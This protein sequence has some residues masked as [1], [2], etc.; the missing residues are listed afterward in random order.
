MA[1]P[2]AVLQPEL[3]PGAVD[4]NRHAI[5]RMVAEAAS[6][7]ARLI[8]LPEACVSDLYREAGKLAEP[9]P[10]P[11]TE[12]I[13]RVC[14]SAAVALPLLEKKDGKVFSACV[15]LNSSGI[16]GVA[17]KAHLYR[18]ASGHDAYQDAEVLAAGAELSVIDL[19]ETKV[20]VLLGFDAEFPEAFRTLAL[21]GAD[22]AVVA[23]N[24][25]EPDR[26]FL[27]GMALRNRLPLLVAN[28]LG[29]KKV[30]PTV[31][32]LTAMSQSLLQDK[33]GA[34]LARCKGSSVI[35][36]ENGRVVAEPGAEVQRDLEELAGVPDRMRIPQA[37]FQEECTL[38]ASF[39]LEELR[40]QRLTT[41]YIAERREA[42]YREK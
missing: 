13:S 19:G 7:G 16:K 17:R 38:K 39:K 29:F 42:L 25:V 37:H 10:G 14:G 3:E 9:V 28:R 2:V 15:L 30:Y 6:S 1:Y 11:S 24:T 8:V 34:F 18:D 22:V 12:M 33:D 40:L 31:P 4:E 26:A 36:D 5:T 32:E 27:S 41:P 23:L 21:G 35:L 20:G